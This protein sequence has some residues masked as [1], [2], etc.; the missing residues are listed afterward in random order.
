M[1]ASK[2]KAHPQQAI[3]QESISR[4]YKVIF[5]FENKNL[6]LSLSSL[7][8]QW[9]AGSPSLFCPLTIA[10]LL[11]SNTITRYWR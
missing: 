8:V 11:E 10:D 4:I 5:R 9:H 6:S 3:S 7:A 1:R 2:A